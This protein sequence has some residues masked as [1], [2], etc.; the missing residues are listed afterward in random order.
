MPL[1]ALVVALVGTLTCLLLVA[2]NYRKTRKV[3]AKVRWDK[4]LLGTL[5]MLLLS[6]I[7]F[8]FSIRAQQEETRNF[9]R[10]ISRQTE[11]RLQQM[12]PDELDLVKETAILRVD[13]DID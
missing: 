9:A 12:T 13:T 6:N 11:L 7:F 4:A 2:F 10:S 8:F 3:L 1:V 5:Q